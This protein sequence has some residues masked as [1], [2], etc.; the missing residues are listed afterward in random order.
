MNYFSKR[1]MGMSD[2]VSEELIALT[3]EK[4]SE[5]L[6]NES[7]IMSDLSAPIPFYEAGEMFSGSGVEAMKAALE[8][9]YNQYNNDLRFV[10]SE[11]VKQREQLL[12]EHQSST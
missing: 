7:E 12:T 3:K 10:K 9:L 5:M 4:L 1:P 6:I 8:S 2:S 11:I